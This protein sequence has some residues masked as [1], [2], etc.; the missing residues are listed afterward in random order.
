MKFAKTHFPHNKGQKGGI[1]G[2]GGGCCCQ[3]R[4]S[5]CHDNIQ[6]NSRFGVRHVTRY[7]CIKNNFRL[8]T[9]T[10]P[11]P[12]N[13][14]TLF[15]HN[16]YDFEDA[17]EH[18]WPKFNFPISLSRI[19]A[20]YGHIHIHIHTDRDSHMFCFSSAEIVPA[21]YDRR[22]IRILDINQKRFCV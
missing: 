19:S 20:Q 11:P 6:S 10:H 3:S 4:A 8:Q 9:M 15:P 18:L 22:F 12:F 14:W 13:C 1:R 17:S 16:F 2:R 21:F 7:S 5:S